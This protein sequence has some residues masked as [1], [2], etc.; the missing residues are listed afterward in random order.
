MQSVNQAQSKDRLITSLPLKDEVFGVARIEPEFDI[1]SLHAGTEGKILQVL[2]TENSEITQGQEVLRLD[3]AIEVAQLNQ[4]K[5]RLGSQQRA[6]VVAG[7]N[8]DQRRLDLIQAEKD[9]LL[10]QSLLAGNAETRQKVND[11]QSEVDQRRQEVV[12]AEAN[13]QQVK[14]KRAE[15]EADIHYYQIQL[16][17]KKIPATMKGKVLNVLV[18]PGEYVSPTT[19]ILE[20][21]PEGAVIANTEVDELFASR[22]S[23]GQKA[24]IYSQMTGEELARGVVTFAAD[25]LRQK[26]LFKDQSTEL[27]DRRVR[28]IKVRLDEGIIPLYGSRVDCRIFLTPE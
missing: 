11:L 18:H 8:L 19:V 3:Q 25:Y 2:V 14:A 7:A 16:S 4:A 5:S 22:V 26:S 17:R 10:A 1:V 21:A 9:L 23:P 15:I 12:I 27:E 28:E 24:V 20:Y 13:L 6:E